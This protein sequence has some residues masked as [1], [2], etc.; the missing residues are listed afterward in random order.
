MRKRTTL[1][2]RASETSSNGY[3]PKLTGYPSTLPLGTLDRG[4][5]RWL[6][7]DGS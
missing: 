7:R 5:V 3:R 4:T 1:I 6:G 2:P